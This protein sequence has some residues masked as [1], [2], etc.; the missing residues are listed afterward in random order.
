M[1]NNNLFGGQSIDWE[2][3]KTQAQKYLDRPV[4]KGTPIT[5]EALTNAAK[6]TYE[7]H[8]TTVPLRLALAQAQQEVQWVERAE[9]P[10]II[11]IMS[12]NMIKE[13]RLFIQI[14][15]RG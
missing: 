4:F 13:Q 15:N 12:V 3:Y 10:L 2:K 6:A 1:G 8:G 5:G 11:L 14:L 7:I 9:A